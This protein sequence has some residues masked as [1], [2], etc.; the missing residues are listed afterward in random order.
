MSRLSHTRRERLTWTLTL[1]ASARA[2]AVLRRSLL[3]VV[4]LGAAGF[5]EAQPSGGR[6]LSVESNV[7]A[8]AFNGASAGV[9]YRPAADSRLLLGAGAY[10]FTLPD[11]FVEQIPGNEGAGFHLRIE[12]ALTVSADAYPWRRDRTGVSVGAALVVAR[13]RATHDAEPGA[14]TYTGGYVVPRVGYTRYLLGGL[15]ATPWVG[16][17]VH[18]RLSGSTDVGARSFSPMSVQFSPNVVFGYSF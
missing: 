3:V 17:E 1:R 2:V 18:R 5:A 12:R 13:F 16:V 7:L 10:A 14:A 4:Y 11:A 9:A 15:Y 6:T 8:F